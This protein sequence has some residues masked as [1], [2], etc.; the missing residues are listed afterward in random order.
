VNDLLA[1]FF[2]SKT[3]LAVVG[4]FVGSLRVA[5]RAK[6]KSMAAKCGDLIAAL[7][8]SLAVVDDLTPKDMPRLALMVGIVAG[9]MCDV[10][11]DSARA[12]SPDTAGGILDFVLGKL[13]Y[14]RQPAAPPVVVA[15]DDEPPPP[16]E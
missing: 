16:P 7:F 6:D 1:G 9:T 8:L 3:L 11:L 15:D 10:L 14:H 12:L 5:M 4:A 13:G 2:A